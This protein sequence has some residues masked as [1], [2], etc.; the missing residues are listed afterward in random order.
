MTTRTHIAYMLLMA[1]IGASFAAALHLHTSKAKARYQAEHLNRLVEQRR[2][3]SLQH[4]VN[5]QRWAMYETARSLNNYG[6]YLSFCALSQLAA[7]YDVNTDLVAI[8]CH[9]E[10]ES[11]LPDSLKGINADPIANAR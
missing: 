7:R 9:L 4:T 6:V 8:P 11:L 5:A 3:D 2:A 1:A 10:A